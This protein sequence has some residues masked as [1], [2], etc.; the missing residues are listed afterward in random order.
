MYVIGSPLASFRQKPTKHPLTSKTLVPRAWRCITVFPCENKFSPEI[1][2]YIAN[3]YGIF[4]CQRAINLK[5]IQPVWL[6]I[7][8][9]AVS[10]RTIR[11]GI[12]Y[13]PSINSN[14]ILATVR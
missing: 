14:S 1:R 10:H 8:V 4:T 7:V 6:E 12:L 5:N 9:G 2:Q 3:V 11:N 13:F